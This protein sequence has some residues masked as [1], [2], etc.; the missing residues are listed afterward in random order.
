[1]FW[2]P[3]TVWES[4]CLKTDILRYILWDETLYKC[5]LFKACGR[6]DLKVHV[7]QNETRPPLAE[8]FRSFPNAPTSSRSSRTHASFVVENPNQAQ[9]LFW[10]AIIACCASIATIML[11]TYDE[12][13]TKPSFI[14]V[15]LHASQNLQVYFYF[16]RV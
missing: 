11:P 12:S 8:D 5:L 3:A 10:F 2:T 13:R 14:P 4:K 6:K 1:M 7:I 15:Y 16:W 9:N